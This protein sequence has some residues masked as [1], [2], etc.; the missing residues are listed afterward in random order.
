[1]GTRIGYKRVSS[2][3]Q[4][5]DR[6]LEGVA[7]DKLFEDKVSGSTIK[8]PG[9]EQCLEYLRAGDV[10]IVHSID[11]L[12]RNLADLENVVGGLTNR[13]VTVQF[14]KEN[15]TFSS[16]STS[17]MNKLM[18]QLL[19]AVAEFERALIRERQREGI[20]AAQAQG[21]HLGRAAAL[22]PEQVETIRRRAAAGEPKAALAKEFEISRPTLYRALK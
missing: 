20:A 21:K 10:L 13:G 15:L 18:F 22:S 11:R 12:A 7:V 3:D 9:L 4:V 14:A 2:V 1:M 17:P 5:T 6:Q 19:G 16:D 8:R